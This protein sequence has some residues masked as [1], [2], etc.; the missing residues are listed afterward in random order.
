[1]PGPAGP[2]G[3]KGDTGAQG[4]QGPQ[5]VKG[6]TGATGTQGPPGS[7][8]PTG[9]TGQPIFVQ[10][11]PPVGVP[12]ST[13]W[14]E[15]DTGALFLYYMDPNTTQ[16][17][18]VNAAGMPE[19]PTDGKPYVRQSA[20][21]FDL[22]ATLN[23][24]IDQAELTAQLGNYLPLAGGT[25]T[26]ALAVNSWLSVS[27]QYI[28]VPNGYIS[29]VNNIAAQYCVAGSGGSQPGGLLGYS[30]GNNYYGI[31]GYTAQGNSFYGSGRIYGSEEIHANSYVRSLGQ[32]AIL[33]G[34]PVNT[35][36]A[37]CQIS[38]GGTVARTTSSTRH[39][40]DIERME[41]EYGDKILKL[42]PIFYRPKDTD[43]PEGWSRFG[44]SA[45]QCHSID[46]RFAASD[47]K[48][49]RDENGKTKL[50]TKMMP[51][52]NPEHLA[53]SVLPTEQRAKILPP[54]PTIMAEQ[55]TGE[56]VYIE[57]ELE[58]I[59]HDL[60][61]IVAGLVNLVQRQEARIAALEAALGV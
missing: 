55:L 21:W 53:W 60:N 50:E 13:L 28:T 26:G 31:V 1:V 59:G 5:G 29:V 9:P 56:V 19:A 7:T 4:V 45:E 15:S 52:P 34:H 12:N 30:A 17:V 35:S 38:T 36:T 39:K 14:W 40:K 18:Q 22:T 16:W 41:D 46:C 57:G 42:E 51:V 23:A 54:E 61:G 32:T 48:V 2:Q 49:A 58:Q 8:G 6:D 37:N 11:T 10:D 33:V 3:A 43:D 27:G 20:A 44:F 47:K 24:Y 25:I